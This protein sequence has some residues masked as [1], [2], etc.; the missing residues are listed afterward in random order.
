MKKQWVA[1]YYDDVT[2]AFNV[3]RNYVQGIVRTGFAR[4]ART[5]QG[6][7]DKQVLPSAELVLKA[8]MRDIDPDNAGEMEF[9]AC[10]HEHMIG[11]HSAVWPLFLAF[12]PIYLASSHLFPA[13]VVGNAQEWK[14][15]KKNQFTIF[16]AKSSFVANKA[17]MTPSHE[18]FFYC[19]FLNI[20]WKLGNVIEYWKDPTV[21][22]FTNLPPAMKKAEIEALDDKRDPYYWARFTSSDAGQSKYGTYSAEGLKIFEDTLKA[23]KVDRKGNPDKCK[24]LEKKALKMLQE[25]NKLSG[26][27]KRKAKNAG[28]GASKTKKNKLSLA[29]E[30]E[31]DDDVSDFV[32][33]DDEDSEATTG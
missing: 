28:D 6:G 22:W 4:W 29:L 1:T 23:I 7:A 15:S 24:K 31:E 14:A 18:A 11:A 13:K 9:F 3:K 19:T 32:D 2:G 33:S 5:R 10:Y 20:E 12:S 30:D 16:N 26:A 21:G 27:G 8:V 25:K 17:M